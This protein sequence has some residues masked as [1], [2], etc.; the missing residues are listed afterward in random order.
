MNIATLVGNLGQAVEVKETEGHKV[1]TLNVATN[2]KYTTA[3]GQEKEG[4][5]WHR[6]VCFGWRAEAVRGLP[7][8]QQVVVIGELKYRQ[9]EDEH[10]TK[11]YATEIVAQVVALVCTTPKAPTV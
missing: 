11:R 10:G 9:W 2:R 4:V 6:V 3:S 5:Q 1:A 8:G 7:K